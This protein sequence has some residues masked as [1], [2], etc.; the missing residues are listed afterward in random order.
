MKQS[1][2]ETAADSAPTG[3]ED[4]S[5]YSEPGHSAA[6]QSGDRPTVADAL[7]DGVRSIAELIQHAGNLLS[8]KLD[9]LKLSIRRAIL[10]TILGMIAGFAAAAIVVVCIVLLFVGAAHGLGAA[11]G[12]RE[13]LG[14]LIVS[15]AVLGTVGVSLMMFLR[16][17]NAASRRGTVRKYERRRTEQRE[18][19][20]R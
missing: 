6:G 7:R 3:P 18:R 12:G 10:Y 17:F 2:G 13:W 5:G 19:F 15:A 20:G 4:P 16:R 1:P 14:D 9:L 11:L 8:A